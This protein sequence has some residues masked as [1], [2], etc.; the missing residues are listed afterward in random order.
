MKTFTKL[1]FGVL[2]IASLSLSSCASTYKPLDPPTAPYTFSE[3]TD[4][5]VYSYQYD[6]LQNKRNKKYAK[7]ET[8]HL[9]RVV[10]VKI[11]NTTDST[12]SI[13][14]DYKFMLGNADV[15]PV[16]P[17]IAANKLKQGVPIYLLYLLLNVR[18]TTEENGK[19]T[20]S[21]FIPTGPPIAGLNMIIAANANRK[22]KEEL[23]AFDI[24]NK[25]VAP[26]ETVYGLLTLQTIA[27]API[28]I[29]RR[30]PVG[31]AQLSTQ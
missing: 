14:N 1:G 26:G 27:P 7:R 22:F 25:T 23:I 19:E 5:L 12:I 8:K 29:A 4:G 16:P 28:R 11:T 2:A 6:L 18:I 30:N 21:T 31:N 17:A 9:M 15:V 20:S 10:A 24:S 13:A 3:K